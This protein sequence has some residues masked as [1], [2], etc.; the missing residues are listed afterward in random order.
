MAIS[1]SA[2]LLEMSEYV[3]LTPSLGRRGYPNTPDPL[4]IMSSAAGRQKPN[5]L[6]DCVKLLKRGKRVIFVTVNINNMRD[7]FNHAV[8]DKT[9]CGKQYVAFARCFAVSA[10]ARSLYRRFAGG[11]AAQIQILSVACEFYID[12]C[13]QFLRQNL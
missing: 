5:R 6:A 3:T 9:V 8:A 7:I 1:I 4:N 2:A 10:P 13:L 12:R 11:I